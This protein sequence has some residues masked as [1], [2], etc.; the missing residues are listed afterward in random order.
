M[1]LFTRYQWEA[2]G[3]AEKASLSGLIVI[4]S[5]PRP[6]VKNEHETGN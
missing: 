2:M 5:I 4:H 6:E 1:Y 3:K